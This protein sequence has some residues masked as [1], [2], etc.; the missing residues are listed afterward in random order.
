MLIFP[1][2]KIADKFK[3][4]VIMPVVTIFMVGVILIFSQLK[5]PNSIFAYLMIVLMQ[6]NYCF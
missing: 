5:K 3:Y 2:G 4:K 1:A 6:A